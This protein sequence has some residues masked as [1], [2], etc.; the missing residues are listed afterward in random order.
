MKK[1]GEMTI[2]M[3]IAIALGVLMLV[4]LVFGVSSGFGGLWERVQQIGGTDN[5]IDSIRSG[6]EVACASNN[7]YEYCEKQRTFKYGEEECVYRRTVEAEGENPAQT[8]GERIPG[9]TSCEGVD[10][11]RMTQKTATGTC[12]EEEVGLGISCSIC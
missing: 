11:C 2:G 5:N 12:A 3:I 8:A 4:L 9:C 7:V 10:N 1:K 6:C